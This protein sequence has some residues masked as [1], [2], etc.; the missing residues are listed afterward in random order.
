MTVVPRGPRDVVMAKTN[1]LLRF[2]RTSR[3]LALLLGVLLAAGAAAMA[4]AQTLTMS[5]GLQLSSTY[6]ANCWQPVHVELSNDSS[7]AIDGSVVIPLVDPQ[8]PAVMAL[9]LTVPPHS[10][11]TAT[12]WAYF[13]PPQQQ[14]KGQAN[15]PPLAMVEFRGRDGARLARAELVGIPVSGNVAR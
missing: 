9:P 3:T 5:A 4:S 10:R 12:Q 15:I 14:P 6:R 13:P 1:P 2:F 7:I 11:V 8:A